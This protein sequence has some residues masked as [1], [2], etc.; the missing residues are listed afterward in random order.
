MGSIPQSRRRQLPVTST[1]AEIHAE[2]VVYMDQQRWTHQ[3]MHQE[4]IMRTTYT[5]PARRRASTER[6]NHYMRQSGRTY[7]RI[8]MLQQVLRLL[9]E[10]GVRY[11]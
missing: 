1:M 3:L 10:E 8:L 4:Q 7:K 2:I 5:S 6:I 11:G 9:T